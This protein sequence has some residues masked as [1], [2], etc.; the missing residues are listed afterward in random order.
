MSTSSVSASTSGTSG[1]SATS[2]SQY[3]SGESL[4]SLGS[5]TP[6]QITGLASGLD[7]NA[8]V[9]ALMTNANQQVTNVENQQT[10]ITALNTNLT[11][12]QLALQ[13]VA[14]DASA[15]AD[16]S[17]F[18]PTQTITST[19]S[20][21]VNATATSS[22]GAVVGGYQITVSALASASQKTFTYSNP[23]SATNFT[24]DGQQFSLAAGA[25]ADS[26]VNQI[27]SDSN[28][29]VWATVTQ[30][31]SGNT[32]ATIVMSNRATGEPD[33]SGDYINVQG[34]SGIL[35]QTAETDGTN[36]QY[37]INGVAG[38]S[39]SNT[40]SG[41]EVPSA[42]GDPAPNVNSNQGATETIPGVALS[43]N[44]ITGSGSPA[45]VD[46]SA[47]GANTTAI[48][49]A[50]SQFIKDY[51][52]AIT[53]IQTQLSQTPSSSDP[54]QGQLYGDPD[55]QQLLGN[56]REMM[57]ATVGGLTGS[58]SSMLDVGVSTGATTGS[59]VPSASALAG[60]LTLDASSLTSALTSNASG[61]QKVLTSW[62]IE[63]SQLVNNEA[64]PGGTI[65]TRITGDNAQINYLSTQ[66]SNMQAANAQQQQELVSEFANMESTLSSS[67][68]TSSWLTSQI[69]ALPGY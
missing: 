31:A 38:Q 14:S 57:D 35:T 42:Q 17:L 25:S 10:G 36:A 5:G 20:A 63:F 62:S 23:S 43:L 1:T 19:N 32:P 54:T 41:A 16:P 52:S 68:S 6:M 33:T 12:I 67:Q 28:A 61:V 64:A 51:N 11:T 24:I 39:T 50:V 55:L 29:T 37:T 7:T 48:S 9:S 45:T 58:M 3:Q 49:T 44:G 2:S 34:A 27:N 66:I 60:N 46:V 22:N 21:L 30:E 65:S 13:T 40:I 26:L 4:T 59:G 8:I 56:M 18:T 53:T 69:S 47:P 15:L